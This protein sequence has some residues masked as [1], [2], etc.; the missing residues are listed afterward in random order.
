ML[1]LLRSALGATGLRDHMGW[2]EIV[3]VLFVG[4]LLITGAA[5]AVILR[6]RLRWV[7]G[8]PVRSEQRARLGTDAADPAVLTTA[9][10]E[11]AP[12]PGGPC[13]ATAPEP[14]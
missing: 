1:N 7:L 11:P 9:A 4:S 14:G 10:L 5:T 13:P 8:G 6:T 3:A 12:V 2:V